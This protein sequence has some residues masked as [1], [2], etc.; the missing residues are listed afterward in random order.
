MARHS[1]VEYGMALCHVM[2]CHVMSCH[3]MYGINHGVVWCG[4]VWCGV[5]WYGM[6]WYGMAWHGMA[7]HSMTCRRGKHYLGF[8]F[9][10]KVVI[11]LYRDLIIKYAVPLS[12]NRGTN[13]IV[14]AS[15]QDSENKTH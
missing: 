9:N 14:N 7:W 6:V 10:Y 2:S 12:N 15:Q 11:I 8:S 13:S 4:V 3:V 1:T 5:V